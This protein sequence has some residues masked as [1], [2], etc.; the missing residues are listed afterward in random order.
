MPSHS[1]ARAAPGPAP[2]VEP[3]PR[4]IDSLTGLRGLA[5]FGVFAFHA[6]LLAHLPDPAPGVPGLSQALA[7]LMRIGWSGVDVFFTLSAFLLALPCARAAQ[8]GTPMPDWRGYLRRRA[9]RILPAYWVQLA[10][11]LAGAL[12]GLAWG[13]AIPRWPGW[14]STLAHA[15]LWLNAW[16][17]VAPCLLYTSPSPRDS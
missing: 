10:L 11:L 14:P 1:R 13:L 4:R 8:A 7:W 17:P 2:R 3:M 5:A 15:V 9:A 16:P 6:W 12:A